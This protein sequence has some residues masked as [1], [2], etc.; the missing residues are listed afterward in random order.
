[1]R[2]LLVEDDEI[3]GDALQ[4][5]FV[6]AGQEVTW[7]RDGIAADQ[8]LL[9]GG[10]GLLLLDL[11]LPFRDGIDLLKALRARGG[12]ILVMVLTARDTVTDRITGL[13]SGADDYLVKPF[14][15]DE[16]HARV[17]ALLRRGTGHVSPLIIHGDI[18]LDRA[19]HSA[20]LK[21]EAVELTRS[22][23]TVLRLLLES[24][25]K[26]VPRAKLESHLYG[27]NQ[28]TDSNAVE[29]YI[30]HLRRKFGNDLIRTL[31]GVGYMVTK[32]KS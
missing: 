2:I 13:D 7:V 28:V 4:A 16:L 10:Y 30:H 11:G 6:R 20:H 14:D 21:D 24:A 12:D 25:G 22:E 8:A 15:L 3:L 27:P 32:E 29:V 18:T 9:A 17:R 31:R 5:S 19:A 23:F 26:V 1:M